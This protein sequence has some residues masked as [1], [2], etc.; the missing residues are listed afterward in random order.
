MPTSMTHFDRASI[1]AASAIVPGNR[2]SV[3]DGWRKVTPELIEADRRAE[4]GAGLAHD[5]TRCFVAVKRVA[6]HIGLKAADLLL[7][8]TLM[9]FSQPQDWDAGQR[10]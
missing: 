6:A 8:D 5:R 3:P 2:K 4:E 7:L 9:A 10:P 1:E